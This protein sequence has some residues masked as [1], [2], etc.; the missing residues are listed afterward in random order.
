MKSTNRNP[1]DVAE[2][3]PISNS[4]ES[5]RARERKTEQETKTDVPITSPPAQILN[6]KQERE[7]EPIIRLSPQIIPVLFPTSEVML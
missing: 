6:Q 5:S 2:K 7:Q 4:D 1:N 3:K